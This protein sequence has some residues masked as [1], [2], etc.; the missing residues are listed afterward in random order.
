MSKKKAAPKK[1]AAPKKKTKAEPRFWFVRAN[2]RTEHVSTLSDQLFALGALGLEERDDT[3]LEKG[4]TGKVT[5]MASFPGEAEARAAKRNL[6][7]LFSP[8]VEVL[9]G[10][11]WRDEWKKHFKPFELCAGVFIR[12]P[13]EKVPAKE[14]AGARVLELEP[15][16]AFGTGLHE[17]TALVAQALASRR[18]E[19]AGKSALDVGTGSGILALVAIALGAKD[20]VGIDVD[21]DAIAVANENATRNSL[22]SCTRFSALP[23][24]AI[25]RSFPVVVA[26]IEADVLI[27]MEPEL[28]RRVAPGGLLVLSGILQTRKDAVRAAFARA[29]SLRMLESPSK[30]E[31]VALV[32]RA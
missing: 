18:K 10:D 8:K 28:V 14:R 25:D 5:V 22:A 29:P 30:G 20:A 7:A 24:D 21:V 31:W 12:P 23:V 4:A 16:R 13:W 26:N 3:T 15:G 19:L 32:Y 2:A 6:S 11:R 27:G 1:R 9:V 17:T